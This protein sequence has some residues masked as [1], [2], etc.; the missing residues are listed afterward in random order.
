MSLQNLKIGETIIIGEKIPLGYKGDLFE[1]I[2][3]GKIV[4]TWT[5]KQRA[6]HNLKE[7]GGNGRVRI[8]KY[9]EIRSK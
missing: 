1:V 3:D 9:I 2:I 4:S 6:E 5:N 8:N 7:L